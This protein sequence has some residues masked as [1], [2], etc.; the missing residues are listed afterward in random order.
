MTVALE[1][2]V[3]LLPSLSDAEKREL[4]SRVVG[5]LGRDF[6]GIESDPAVCGGDA[7]IIRTRIPVWVLERA[8]R[9]GVSER[10]LLEDYPTL[11]AQDLAN[12]WAYV[13]ANRAEIDRQIVENETA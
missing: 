1:Q 2:V 11:R 9:G 10:E 5:D 8:R 12:A 7:R 6:P 4:V 13:E 3:R